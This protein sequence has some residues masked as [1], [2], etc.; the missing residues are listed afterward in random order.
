MFEKNVFRFIHGWLANK[1]IVCPKRGGYEFAR[2][3]G[4]A[5]VVHTS[6]LQFLK[7]LKQGGLLSFR[8]LTQQCG[9]RR[10]ALARNDKASR[11]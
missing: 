9:G 2:R 1:L 5:G 10:G 3:W 11:W 8:C 6:V 7:S 4:K